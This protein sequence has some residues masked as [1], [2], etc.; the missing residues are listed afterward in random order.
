MDEQQRS[1]FL[2]AL[3][4]HAPK[5]L[6][7]TQGPLY[8]DVWKRAELSPRDRS[9]VTIAA[10]VIGGNTEELPFHVG[11]GRRNGLTPSE[12][13]EAITHLAFY[14]GWPKAI[15]AVVAAK[16]ELAD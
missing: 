5:L 12:I 11:L 4:E 3:T 7:L 6:E 10:L 1:K 8:A 15:S 2:S 16:D 13:S 9:L 14:G